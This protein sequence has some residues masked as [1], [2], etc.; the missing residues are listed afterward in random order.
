M[1][2]NLDSL[3]LLE[4]QYNISDML[5][6]CQMDNITVPSSGEGDFIIDG[7]SVERN[8]ILVRMS[9]IGG[10]SERR[11]PPR[12]LQKFSAFLLTLLGLTSSRGSPDD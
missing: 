8:H 9:V 5:V 11:L 2:C 7:L 3:L 6:Q 1:C 10:P 4:S 12:A